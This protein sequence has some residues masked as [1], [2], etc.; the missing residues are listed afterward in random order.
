MWGSHN[1]MQEHFFFGHQAVVFSPAENSLVKK[2]TR[3]NWKNVVL[4]TI[5]F[6][7]L[8]TFINFLYGFF[9]KTKV[10]SQVLKKT[11]KEQF[12]SIMS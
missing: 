10:F 9:G 5:I 11:W 8:T 6:Q 4:F 3:N 12:V 2:L 7:L 1:D